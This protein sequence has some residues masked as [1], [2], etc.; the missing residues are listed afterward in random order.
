MGSKGGYLL[1]SNWP[2][3]VY[4]NEYWIDHLWKKDLLLHLR[5][6]KRLKLACPI[7]E[8]K[9]I[10]NCQRISSE[11]LNGIELISMPRCATKSEKIKNWFP[12]TCRLIKILLNAEIF[13]YTATGHPII[14]AFINPFLRLV[15]G[16]KIIG[17]VESSFWRKQSSK[18]WDIF[19]S[20]FSELGVRVASYFSHI[21]ICTQTEYIK[22]LTFKNTA[23]YCISAVWID[24]DWI[25]T[26]EAQEERVN[27]L[28]SDFQSGLKI[29]FCG[30]LRPEKGLDIL[31]SACCV[32]KSR[33][34]PFE[35]V[36]FGDGPNRG[37]YEEMAKKTL[38]SGFDF[39]GTVQYG[40]E[41]VQE[42]KNNHILVVP[43]RSDERPRII[44][45]AGSQGLVTLGSETPGILD[46]LVE[47][48]NGYLFR[49]GDSNS[50]AEKLIS[51]YYDPEQL[52]NISRNIVRFVEQ[53]THENMH[54]LR[55]QILLK[56]F[57]ENGNAFY[58]AFR[59]A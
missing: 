39:K 20:R 32:L 18:L 47:G 11:V 1:V 13:H 9:P 22:S 43:N 17:V 42:L 35:L 26:R 23:A 3:F 10:A 53:N 40:K 44:F 50:L 5:Y 38:Q 34:I 14:Y 29:C 55:Y 54:K 45:D 57:H 48:E 58:S 4:E 56:H 33:N 12:F 24:Q 36:V 16:V 6:I 51:V 25:L 37:E 15:S 21:M 27:W 41:F 2:I 30:Q 52:S 31:I 49:K 8:S 19:V 7:V 59:E 28:K 46:I